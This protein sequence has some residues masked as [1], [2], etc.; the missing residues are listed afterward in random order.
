MKK[1]FFLLSGII[2]SI[3]VIFAIVLYLH[4]KSEIENN[5]KHIEVYQEFGGI[6][7]EDDKAIVIY[8]VTNITGEELNLR[9]NDNDRQI[10]L[11]IESEVPVKNVTTLPLHSDNIFSHNETWEYKI[12]IETNGKPKDEI[13]IEVQFIPKGVKTLKTLR[14][15][16][17]E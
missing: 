9:F 7:I 16:W 1:W 11:E 14:T 8:K 13:N 5:Y 17:S 10:D 6:N 4:Y 15:V 2:F 3:I 12:E